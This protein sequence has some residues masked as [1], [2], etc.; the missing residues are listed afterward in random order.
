MD[1]TLTGTDVLQPR[2]SE[3]VEHAPPWPVACNAFVLQPRMS[4]GVEHYC[5]RAA[6][7]RKRLPGNRARGVL[8]SGKLV[9][10]PG[11]GW[12]AMPVRGQLSGRLCLRRASMSRSM[13]FSV[14]AAVSI[15]QSVSIPTCAIYSSWATRTA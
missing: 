4:E 3:G 12:G 15:S 6:E 2:M 13:P 14:I 10:S 1:G 5:V 9:Y 11:D 8:P 7:R